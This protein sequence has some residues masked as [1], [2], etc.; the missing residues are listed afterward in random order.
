MVYCPVR[1]W[2]GTIDILVVVRGGLACQ[3][4]G[5]ATRRVVLLVVTSMHRCTLSMVYLL[6]TIRYLGH[7]RSSDAEVLYK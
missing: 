5:A 4:Y 6:R 3:S 1:S 7:C 2:Y